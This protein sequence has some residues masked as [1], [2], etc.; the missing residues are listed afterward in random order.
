M[1]RYTVYETDNGRYSVRPIDWEG[2]WD[3]KGRIQEN[4]LNHTGIFPEKE[5]AEFFCK[6]KNAEEQGKLLILPCKPGDILYE[7]QFNKRKWE[8]FPFKVNYFEVM[9]SHGKTRIEIHFEGTQGYAL[10][11]KN[12]NLDEG[13]YLTEQEANEA[14]EGMK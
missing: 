13:W 11:D 4:G 12:G 9:K 3:K 2:I 7:T 6:A 5:D 1:D 14:L 8:I 10:C